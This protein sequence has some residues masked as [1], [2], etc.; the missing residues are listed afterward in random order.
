MESYFEETSAWLG[1]IRVQIKLAQCERD[2]L[3]IAVVHHVI[4]QRDVGHGS[5]EHL[6][7]DEVDGERAYAA[8]LDGANDSR[9]VSKSAATPGTSTHTTSMNKEDGRMTVKLLESGVRSG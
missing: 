3:H 8:D 5:R 9:I 2:A 1:F 7:C 4:G 6:W